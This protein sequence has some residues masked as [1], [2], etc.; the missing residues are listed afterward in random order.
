VGVF[1]RQLSLQFVLLHLQGHDLVHQHALIFG[2]Q[3]CTACKYF[4]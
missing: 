2:P 3:I 1:A 4:L